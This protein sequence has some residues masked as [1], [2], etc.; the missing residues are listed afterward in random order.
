MNYIKAVISNIESVDN[1]NLVSFSV[2]EHTLKMISLELNTSLQEGSEVILAAKSSTIALARTSSQDLSISNQLPCTISSLEIGK[3][4]CVVK[5]DFCGT[6]LESLITKESALRMKLQIGEDV[7]ALIKSS[8]L[9][10]SE[11]L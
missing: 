5:L 7:I 1:V 6:P 8:E 4:L 3:L 9:S 10:I 2:N 11:I